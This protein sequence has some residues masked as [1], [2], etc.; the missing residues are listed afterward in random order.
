[1][2][3]VHEASAEGKIAS[4]ELRVSDKSIILKI[5]CKKSLKHYHF[6]V[7]YTISG[8]LNAENNETL[9]MGLV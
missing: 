7:H 8:Y 1:M 4:K 2:E 9:G 5:R 6:E 3:G